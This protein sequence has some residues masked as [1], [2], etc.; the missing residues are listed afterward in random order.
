LSGAFY[1]RDQLAKSPPKP[2]NRSA[3]SMRKENSGNT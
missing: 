2:S 1:C 3:G